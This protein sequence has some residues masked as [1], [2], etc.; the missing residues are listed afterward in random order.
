MAQR[1]QRRRTHNGSPKAV[2][3]RPLLLRGALG[4]LIVGALV[5]AVARWAGQP[6]VLTDQR[7][8]QRPDQHTN[9]RRDQAV[10]DASAPNASS[11]TPSASDHA[12]NETNV[13]TPDR[14]LATDS[15]HAPSQS[16]TKRTSQ[17]AG[18]DAELACVPGLADRTNHAP[19]AELFAKASPS[20]D[21][22]WRSE[23]FSELAAQ[24]LSKLAALCENLEAL[25][26]DQLASLVH[27]G[28]S[29]EVLRPIVHEVFRDEVFTVARQ[30]IGE[31]VTGGR[32]RSQ[33][34]LQLRELLKI[35]SHAPEHPPHLKFKIVRTE[36]AEA[37]VRTTAYVEIYGTSHRFSQRSAQQTATW[38]C[39]WL[40]PAA[41]ELPV[42]G[43][44]HVSDYEEVQPSSERSGTFRD[45]TEA[46]F[47]KCP[48][49]EQQLVYGAD[50]WYGNMDVAFGIHHGNQG[51]ALGDVNGDGRED[52]FLC[53]PAGLPCR[54]YLQQPDGTL[55][56]ATYESGL[57]WLDA[58]RSALFADFDNDGDQDLAVSLNYS[59]ILFENYESGKFIKRTR[60]DVH[61][62]PTSMAA[63]DYDND[64]DL[65]LYICGYN[66]R[67]MTAA[68]DIFANPVPYHDANNGAPNF[69]MRSDGDW[70]FSDV[71]QAIGLDENNRRFSFAATWEDYDNDGDQDLYVA[72]DF[73][74]N[75]LYRNDRDADGSSHFH[76]VA[77][78]AGVEDIGAGMSVA[79]GDYNHDGWMD[80][81]V[82]NMFS[83]AGNRI[84]SQR[85]FKQT[86]DDTTRSAMQRH[87]RGNSLFENQK[88]GTFKDVSL[89]A[90]VTLGRWAWGSLFTD[91]NND[92]WDDLYVAN[93]FF[94]TPDPGDL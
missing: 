80:L 82:S 27:E 77:A 62:W 42:L 89:E 47:A 81:Y 29:G 79:W 63:A 21:P 26:E 56:D 31:S 65:D 39:V 12:S 22:E 57:D 46:L 1:N 59:I 90:H 53:Q 68:G 94:T 24:Q 55:A 14:D 35:Y 33:F 67:G 10:D 52:L 16:T 17:P 6:P 72:N 73:G 92:G 74:R 54:F 2:S 8:D 71:T 11:Q 23:Q 78:E 41:G 66:P 64:G 15:P 88:D 4:L 5:Y 18:Q 7:P 9:E 43:A 50:H 44:V 93:G 20:A 32:G 60:I 51:L 49:Y 75:N 36:M 25:T 86:A 84:V 37:Q 45:C 34:L 30:P 70:N 48:S 83:S 28:Y 87:A 58:S 38:D 19:L 61:S 40:P 3:R 76:D 91:L 85:Q 13:A 69:M